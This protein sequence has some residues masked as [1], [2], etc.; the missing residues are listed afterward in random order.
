MLSDLRESGSIEQDADVV[1]FIYR[2]EV[3]NQ[4]TPDQGIAEILIRKQ[5]NGPIGDIKL[6]FENQYTRFYNLSPDEEGVPGEKED[7]PSY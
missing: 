2:D 3:Y 6:Q 4:E 1:A 5:R 7:P